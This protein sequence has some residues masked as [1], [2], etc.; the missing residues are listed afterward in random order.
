MYIFFNGKVLDENENEAKISIRSKIVNYGMGVFEGIRAYWNEDDN[1]LY[2][3]KLEEHYRRFLQS[4]K[5]LNLKVDYDVEELVEITKNLLKKNE[6]RQ[7]T[8]IRPIAFKNDP[9]IGVNI[10]DNTYDSVAIY[11]APL[12]K[13]IDSAELRTKVSSWTRIADN[14]LPPRIKPCGGY[15][16]SVLA[17]FEATSLGY[18]EAILLNR[19]GNVCEGPGENIFLYKN[20]FLQTPPASDDILE[21]ITRAEIMRIAKE[22]FKIKVVE[23]SIART[24]LYNTDELFFT[25]TAMELAPIVE[26][27]GIKVGSGKTGPITE[28]LR[29]S[30]TDITHGRDL[31]YKDS[32]TKVYGIK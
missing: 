18:D 1:E 10:T 24:E 17:S 27:D 30:L 21:G 31:R 14:M 19:N 32:L 5:V 16:N 15:I 9:V 11:T 26:V 20:G 8:Y 4:A 22:D 7:D 23:K 3:F 12:G 13:Y 2:A 6:C 28:K 25:G 29:K